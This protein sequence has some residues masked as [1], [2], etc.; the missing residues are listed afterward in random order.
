MEFFE[1]TKH[2]EERALQRFGVEGKK[3]K[4]F[5]NQEY[6]NSKFIRTGKDNSKIHLSDNGIYLVVN[7]EQKSIITCYK[8]DEENEFQYKFIDDEF[9]LKEINLLFEKRI[10][11]INKELTE[12]EIKKSRISIKINNIKYKLFNDDK[13]SNKQVEDLDLFIE[14]KKHLTQLTREINKKVNLLVSQ[15]SIILD[16]DLTKKIG[17]SWLFN[18]YKGDE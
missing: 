9:M 7:Y 13:L 3:V 11:D 1:V 8:E 15:F 6:N 10:K 14:Q 4:L 18:K 5:L 2:A 12:L 17:H 16:D